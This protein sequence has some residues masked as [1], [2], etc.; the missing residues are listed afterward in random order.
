[1]RSK[2]FVPGARP[3]LFLKA[4]HGAADAISIDL[5]DA[6]AEG[7]KAEARALVAGFLQSPDVKASNKTI[8]VRINAIGTPH[9]AQDLAAVAL[10]G[11]TMLNLPKAESADDIAYACAALARAESDNS[12][13][14][15]ISILANIE[16]PKGLR[17]AHQIA[18][19]DPRVAGLQLGYADLFEPAGIARRDS[20]NVHAAMFAVRMAASEAGIFA[21]DGAFPD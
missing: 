13:T 16:S 2:L 21:Y 4:L 7:R 8:I 19:A 10:P 17:L 14:Q 3:E 20:A 1:M 9:F 18:R 15:P 5:E 12:V 11:L 6:V